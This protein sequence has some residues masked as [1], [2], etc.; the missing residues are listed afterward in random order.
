MRTLHFLAR[1]HLWKTKGL[2]SVF[3]LM[4]FRLLAKN[5]NL[6][7]PSRLVYPTKMDLQRICHDFPEG[8]LLFEHPSDARA[9]YTLEQYPLQRGDVTHLHRCFSIQKKEKGEIKKKWGETK[10]STYLYLVVWNIEIFHLVFQ[11]GNKTRWWQ[12]QIFLL[13]SP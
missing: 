11:G 1:H 13:C 3:F 10:C 6:K 2:F 8:C 9:K 4:N 12:L 5:W 7:K